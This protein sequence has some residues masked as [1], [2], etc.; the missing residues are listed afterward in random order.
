MYNDRGFNPNALHAEA[1]SVLSNYIV[2][3]LVATVAALFGYKPR[4]S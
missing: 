3:M 1:S 4:N 2:V